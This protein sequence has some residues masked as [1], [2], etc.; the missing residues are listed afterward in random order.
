MSGGGRRPPGGAW[1]RGVVRRLGA[2]LPFRRRGGAGNASGEPAEPGP[3]AP[4]AAF[5]TPAGPGGADGAGAAATAGAGTPAPGGPG[6]SPGANPAARRR[7]RFQPSPLGLFGIAAAA[8]FATLLVIQLVSGP[9]R[10]EDPQAGAD[11]GT[12]PEDAATPPEGTA[13]IMVAGDSIAQGSSGDFTWRY[14]LW[15]HLRH[16]AGLDVDFVGP[17]TTL[18]DVVAG[19]QGD[20]RYADPDFDTDHAALWGSTA[21]DLADSVGE[22]VAEYDPHY[23]L[24]MA[25]VNDFVA[26]GSAQSALGEIRDAV[27]TARVARGDIQI[28]IGE[29]TPVRG[30]TGSDPMNARIAEFNAALPGLAA[31]ISGADSPVTVARTAR[32]YAPAE[33]TWDGTHPNAR[34]ELKIAA[35]FADALAATLHLGEPYPRPLP[36]VR[37]G[38]RR[39]PEVTAEAVARDVRLTWDPVPGATRYHVFQRRVRPDP[40]ELVRLPMEVA[41]ADTGDTP[42]ATIDRLLAGATYEFVVQPFKGDNGGARSDPVEITAGDDPPPAPEWVR[43]AEDRRTL[44]WAQVPDATHFEVWRRP[45]VCA[46]PSADPSPPGGDGAQRPDCR[47]RNDLGPGRGEG[48]QSAAVVSGDRRWTVAADGAPGWELAVRAHRDFVPGAYSATVVYEVPG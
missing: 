15:R 13:R 7:A 1:P 31:E 29:L 25:G 6:A 47:P 32:G 21:A 2:A 3:G 14:R 16:R 42:S 17:H 26:G 8:M 39:A 44:V 5:E 11:P 37:T 36:D 30:G 12:A 9:F 46:A 33:D 20:S 24:L 35:A 10:V 43:L 22:H 38:P 19:E 27:S 48:W 40:D 23:L 28:V 45:L 34:G 41:A 18:L 4:A